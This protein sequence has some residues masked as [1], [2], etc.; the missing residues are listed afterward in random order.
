MI[1]EMST[2]AWPGTRRRIA[3]DAL[4]IGVAVGT[5]G[6]SY[7]ALGVTNGL[8][9]VQTCALS[10]LAFT[11]GS[12]FAYVGV[13]GSG[14]S[15]VS[16]TATALLLGSRNLLYGLRIAPLL[17]I[18]GPLQR[19]AA[20]QVVIDETTAM[21]LSH[22]DPAE[23]RAS[24]L[25]F[26]S[27]ALAVYVCWNLATLVGALGAT[28]LGDPKALGLDAAVGAAFLALLW[29]RLQGRLTATVAL[30]AAGVALALTPVVTPGVPVLVAG[31]VAV[32]VGVRFPR[33]V[34][35]VDRKAS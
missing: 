4:S 35:Q 15:A 22:E 11:G 16:G 26:W 10:V 23:P 8:S 19:A 20:A 21:T 2:H 13:I 18:R 25:A 1:G 6:V 17:D 28:V 24:R 3:R 5:Y 33:R 12:Q 9:V 29:P 14:G 27:T 34:L 7:G 32:A 30:V 31:L